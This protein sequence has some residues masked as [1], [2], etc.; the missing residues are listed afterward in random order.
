MTAPLWS[1]VAGRV[2]VVL[3]LCLLPVAGVGSHTAFG[4]EE[5]L[6]DPAVVTISVTIGEFD[7]CAVAPADCV[8]GGALA[9]TGLAT[10]GLPVGVGALLAA[11]GAGI[12]ALDRRRRP[13]SP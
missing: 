10:I 13:E 8:G 5:P 1:G 6:D 9:A 4:A 3:A 11:I 2:A 12:Y 7:L